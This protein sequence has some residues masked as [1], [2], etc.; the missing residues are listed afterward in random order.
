MLP[1]GYSLLFSLLLLGGCAPEGP[2]REQAPAQ[3]PATSEVLVQAVDATTGAE[4]SDAEVTI[5]YLARA[6]ITLDAAGVDRVPSA[7]PYRITGPVAEDS[8][9]LELRLEAPS[10]FKLDTVVSVA[11]GSTA[12]PFRLAMA[13][14]TDRRAAGGGGGAPTG[15]RTP[16]APPPQPSG[17]EDEDR[18]SL[19]AGDRAFE[20]GDWRTAAGQ[21]RRMITPRNRAGAYAREY[22]RALVRQGIAFINLGDWQGALEALQEAVAFDFREYTAF[23][24]LGQVQ[25][26][27]GQYEAGR[28]SLNHIREWLTLHISEA[29][30]PVVFALL[31]FQ[32][33]MCSYGEF[34][35][36]RIQAD[37][38]RARQRALGEFQSFMDKANAFPAMPPEIQAAVGQAQRIMSE[39]R[40]RDPGP[41]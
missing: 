22:Q 26:V 25:C 19:L 36:A 28:Q 32:L 40:V 23:F 17:A 14:R 16:A 33:G 13:P 39:I 15:G 18:T 8:L 1:R 2:R 4:L 20:T 12:G 30:R 3:E 9:V 10:Y 21:Y 31:D 11:R 29:Q 41:F 6:P 37:L 27:V 7:E 34:S 24:Y 5:R 35:N 38:D